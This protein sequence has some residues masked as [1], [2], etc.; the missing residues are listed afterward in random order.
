MDFEKGE[1]M[2]EMFNPV[3]AF[4]TQINKHTNTQAYQQ[5]QNTKIQRHT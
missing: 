4:R 5:T 3:E 1:N 2:K